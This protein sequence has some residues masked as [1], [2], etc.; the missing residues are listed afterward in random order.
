[1]DIPSSTAES[2]PFAVWPWANPF[3]SL[4]LSFP[5]HAKRK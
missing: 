3:P 4:G 5:I 1:M 2:V